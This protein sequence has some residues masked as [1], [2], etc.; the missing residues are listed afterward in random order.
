[1]S[2]GKIVKRM[3]WIFF[4]SGTCQNN[5]YRFKMVFVYILYRLTKIIGKEIFCGQI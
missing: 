1:M 2:D 5:N 4:R 3:N